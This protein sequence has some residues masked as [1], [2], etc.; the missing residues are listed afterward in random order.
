MLVHPETDK[1]FQSSDVMGKLDLSRNTALDR[2]EEAGRIRIAD[3]YE[4]PCQGGETTVVKLKDPRLQ[5]IFRGDEY[6]TGGEDQGS[7]GSR[8]RSDPTWYF[9]G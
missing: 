3:V 6:L 7:P 8:G 5:A 2:M 9:I 4:E 1:S